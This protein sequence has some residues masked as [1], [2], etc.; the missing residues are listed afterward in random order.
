[1]NFKQKTLLICMSL[2]FIIGGAN[3]V[4]TKMLSHPPINSFTPNDYDQDIIVSKTMESFPG[5]LREE[6]FIQ[7]LYDVL[8]ACKR[9][10]SSLD[11]R[12]MLTQGGQGEWCSTSGEW[13]STRGES[14]NSGRVSQ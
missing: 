2:T 13:C 14:R 5:A 11:G 12:A 6:H 7:Q 4:Y 9:A 1:M 3:H 8:H 10:T